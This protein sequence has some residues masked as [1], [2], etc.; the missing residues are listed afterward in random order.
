MSEDRFHTK[1]NVIKYAYLVLRCSL[2]LH[3]LVSPF[4]GAL[5]T[6]IRGIVN[7]CKAPSLS[8]ENTALRAQ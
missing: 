1:I 2:S 4:F 6:I 3:R 7:A 5:L 8:E